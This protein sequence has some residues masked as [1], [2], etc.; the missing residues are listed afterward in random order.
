M[1][2]NTLYSLFDYLG[3][4]AGPQLGNEVYEA[5][6]EKGLTGKIEERHVETRYYEGKVLLYPKWFLVEY[7]SK[8]Y[9]L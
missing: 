1:K 6:K 2:D 3:K 8:N 7:F 5:A 9:N 4:P